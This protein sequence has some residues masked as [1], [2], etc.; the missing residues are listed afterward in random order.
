MKFYVPE[1]DDAV[2][3]HYDF[4]HD[5]L[6]TLEKS[7]RE[8]NFI[9]DIFDRATLPIDGVLISREQVEDS[10]K[11]SERLTSYG[12]YEDPALSIPDWL[13]TISDCGAWGYK[14]LPFP[15][16]SNRGMLEFYES[17]DVDVGVT[18][19]HL[20]LGSGKEQG[21]LYLDKRAFDSDFAEDDLPETLT[22]QVDVMVDE[23]PT[24]WPEFVDEYEP[25]ITDREI[26]ESFDES[27][28][29]GPVSAVLHRLKDDPRAVYRK[30]DKEFR[31]EL[32]LNNARD[33]RDLYDEGEWSFRLMAAFQGWDPQSYA[34]A[35]SDILEMDYQ[36]V[37]I[38]GVA[39][40]STNTVRDIV[41]EVGAVITDY[42][43]SHQTRIDAHVFGFAKPDAFETVG[44]S[45]MTS[46][47]SASMLRSAWTGGKNY[48]LHSDEKYDAIRV[49]YP[50][51]GD[52]L[53]VSIEKALMAQETLHALRA[54]DR[55][56]SIA[57]AIEDWYDSAM[58]ALDSLP[59]F[60]EEHRHDQRYNRNR[61]RDV[62]G[63]LREHFEHGRPL[64]AS[65]GQDFRREI[66]GLL[67]DDDADSPVE[68]ERYEDVIATA[69]DVLEP[70]PRMAEAM[71]ELETD[72][73]AGTFR[74]I[75]P[76]VEDYANSDL[77]NDEGLLE[78]YRRTLRARPWERCD[79][80]I[81]A[82]H[83]IEVAIFRGNNRNRRRGFHNT[84][85]FYDEFERDLPKMI[86]AVPADSGFFGRQRVEEYLKDE[87]EA[88]WTTVHDLPV[89]EIGVCDA[90]GFYEWWE[91]SPGRVSL[92]PN[93][94]DAVLNE[95]STR[96]DSLFIFDEAGKIGTDRGSNA[97]LADKPQEI[98]DRVLSR[99][100]YG[101]DFA[102]ANN[103]QISLGEF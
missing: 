58:I 44:R 72:V 79:C 82:E 43:R 90:N 41:S 55:G 64:Y 56:D 30:D 31:Y 37:G 2:D 102:P 29:S 73:E 62:R 12:V 95:K 18:I 96:Y 60:L 39:G 8:R 14:S 23:W 76:V 86:A 38:G 57:S 97:I 34:D 67:R 89:I 94:I 10:P 98:R 91:P 68:F 25:S 19:D 51:P 99:L 7:D 22:E 54:F 13:P 71:H 53:A 1:W 92:D 35:V 27:D 63:E 49:R 69:W 48:H 93:G 70:F 103:V 45:G 52:S 84:R 65:F 78:G 20:V 59:D 33:M 17:L 32:T 15:P 4:V 28:F 24:N 101:E 74:H 16:Y 26:V 47:D 5:E 81:C 40:S 85:R 83:G 42:Q 21:R 77:I 46:F 3:A 36:Y 9:W 87:H 80:P 88:F 11:K 6:S 50:Q 75:W 66:V 100:G 61:L